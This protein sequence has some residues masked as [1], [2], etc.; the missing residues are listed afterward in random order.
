MKL[1]TRAIPFCGV[2]QG[3]RYRSSSTSQVL[4]LRLLCTEVDDVTIDVKMAIEKQCSRA[5]AN[6]SVKLDIGKL[7]I[8][9]SAA[10][11]SSHMLLRCRHGDIMLRVLMTRSQQ[12]RR[13]C[14]PLASAN[15]RILSK[16]QLNDGAV[17]VAATLH[18]ATNGRRSAI[19]FLLTARTGHLP[20][21]PNRA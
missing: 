15:F 5:E 18:L 17:N 16:V 9:L 20:V 14:R 2:N 8:C 19:G 7:I 1:Q 13:V 11:Y 4:N 10:F 21:V 6:Q 3:L 12:H